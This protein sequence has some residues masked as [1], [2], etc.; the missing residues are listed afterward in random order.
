[1]KNSMNPKLASNPS[2][3]TGESEFEVNYDSKVDILQGGKSK[4][5]Y[6][7]PQVAES[8]LFNKNS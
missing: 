3:L 1:M 4:D 2:G 6:V 5:N 8:D 7:T